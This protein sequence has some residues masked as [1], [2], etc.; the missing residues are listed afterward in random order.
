[1]QAWIMAAGFAALVS[2]SPAVL[3]G[4]SQ[5]PHDEVNQPS[6][7]ESQNP[8]DAVNQPGGTLRDT[9]A[10]NPNALG[11]TGRSDQIGN[12]GSGQTDEGAQPPADNADP[13]NRIED[14]N[15]DDRRLH[16]RLDG[17][18]DRTVDPGFN[19]D[20]P[21]E[22]VAPGQGPDVNSDSGDGNSATSASDV[23][24]RAGSR[25]GG[26]TSGSGNASGSGGAGGAR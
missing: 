7:D 10:P 21:G 3:A 1:M 5:N 9:G 16:D 25:S 17:R 22:P 15:D 26:T 8:H 20:N 19:S 12:G 11:R 6:D 13:S 24:P 18:P 23:A 14:I 4:A 2:L